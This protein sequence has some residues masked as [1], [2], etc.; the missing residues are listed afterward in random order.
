ML[1]QCYFEFV[2][3]CKTL[4]YLSF[5][6]CVNQTTMQSTTTAFV[7]FVLC[8]IWP[9]SH[10]D[11]IKHTTCQS[12]FLF[13]ANQLKEL[14][15]VTFPPLQLQWN[16]PSQN[17]VYSHL[18]MKPHFWHLFICDPWSM[19]IFRPFLPSSLWN[20]ISY[21]SYISFIYCWKKLNY[22]DFI[23]APAPKWFLVISHHFSCSAEVISWNSE[24]FLLFLTAWHQTKLCWS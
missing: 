24:C 12:Q 9:M 21:S 14:K 8:H 16:G 22:C 19:F 18:G 23:A 17:V 10:I 20:D 6:S 13:K 3:Q 11:V 7:N 15:E 5:L 1:Y 2:I 4:L